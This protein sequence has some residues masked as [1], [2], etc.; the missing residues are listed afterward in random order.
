MYGRIKKELFKVVYLL[1]GS[2]DRACENLLI[3]K[4]GNNTSE[5]MVKTIHD[6]LWDRRVIS[7]APQY[8]FQIGL[9]TIA[10]AVVLLVEDRIFNAAIVVAI[11][12]TAYIVF[13]IP[14]SVAATPRKV[15]GGH[16]VAVLVGGILSYLFSF[17]FLGTLA[18]ESR[19]FFDIIAAASV[20]LSIL[21]M[22][23]TNTEHP[24]A[25]GTALG[26]M[27]QGFSLNTVAFIM[28][29][30]LLLCIIRMILRP[31]LQNLL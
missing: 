23:S 8:L 10:L 30:A 7:H 12:S 22:V 16:A 13:V 2:L 20:G 17:T 19:L 1:R 14:D 28:V 25:A 18:V 21:I 9:A 5:K 15:L 3:G 24:P 11:A 27:F 4:P 29:S 26:L 6:F 31:R